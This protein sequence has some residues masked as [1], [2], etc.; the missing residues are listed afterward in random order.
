MKNFKGDSVPKCTSDA[1]GESKKP[2]KRKNAPEKS[3]KENTKRTRK[4]PPATIEQFFQ[5]SS[6][7]TVTM[8]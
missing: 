6:D 2:A 3:G 1:H 4:K 8:V 7:S 5:K